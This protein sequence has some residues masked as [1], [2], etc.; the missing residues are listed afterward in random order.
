MQIAAFF[1]WNWVWGFRP[2]F[3]LDQPIVPTR[4]FPGVPE[5]TGLER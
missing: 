2:P 5:R 4:S 3:A 1:V